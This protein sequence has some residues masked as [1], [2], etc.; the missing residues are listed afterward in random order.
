MKGQSSLE[1]VAI[2]GVALVL[3]LPFVVEGQESMI[4][5]ATGSEDARFQASLNELGSTA[6]QVSASGPRTTRTV[7]LRI[8]SNIANVY[9]QDQAIIYEMDRGGSDKNFSQSFS[10]Q[11][12]ANES[13][14]M[15]QEGLYILKIQSDS[16]NISISPKQ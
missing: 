12:N 8:P 9:V 14:L 13:D 2:I 7:K 3:S 10:T 6:Q 15:K 1:F 16:G 4:E 5:L 11:I